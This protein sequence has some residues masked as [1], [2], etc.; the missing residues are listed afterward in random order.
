[1]ALRR[2]ACCCVAEVQTVV[3]QSSRKAWGVTDVPHPRLINL[4]ALHLD[5]PNVRLLHHLLGA[6][7]RSSEHRI[8][9]SVLSRPG[10]GSLSSFPLCVEE[11]LHW[12]LS[13]NG[14]RNEDS[15]FLQE[16]WKQHSDFSIYLIQCSL[17]ISGQVPCCLT[18]LGV[19]HP[20]NASSS[21]MSHCSVFSSRFPKAPMPCASSPEGGHVH[22]LKGLPLLTVLLVLDK[23]SLPLDRKSV[24]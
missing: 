13:L 15:C 21:L 12:G 14:V 7:E 2:N 9:C 23:L 1:M 24:V 5:T 3:V 20:L 6:E 8:P 10:Q 4:R 19:H 11:M 18:L 17:W 22:G 16:Y